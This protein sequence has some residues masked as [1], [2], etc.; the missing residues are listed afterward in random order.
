M[1][2]RRERK[3]N[4]LDPHG[5]LDPG[6]APSL[7]RFEELRCGITGLVHGELFSTSKSVLGT[8]KEDWV[9][10]APCPILFTALV[11]GFTSCPFLSTA[12]SSKK[13]RL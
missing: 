3:T 6:P 13:N 9:N 2:E 4:Q 12:S 10:S 7:S 8:P 11:F 5:T 1:I